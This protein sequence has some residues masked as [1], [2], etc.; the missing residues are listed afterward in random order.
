MFLSPPDCAVLAGE[1]LDTG[2]NSFVVVVEEALLGRW[3]IRVV[4]ALAGLLLVDG[5]IFCRPFEMAV[6]SFDFSPFD[7]TE[8]DLVPPGADSAATLS[9][10]V[11]LVTGSEL[12]TAPALFGRVTR[13]LSCFFQN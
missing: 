11:L 5:G 2:E 13:R 9:L 3:L 12:R 10:A 4:L 8:A 6:C 1:L 7:A